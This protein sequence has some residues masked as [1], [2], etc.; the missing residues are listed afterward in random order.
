MMATAERTK[1][2]GE[3]YFRLNARFP[4]TRIRNDR[5]LA[6][7]ESV[8]AELLRKKCDRGEKTYLETLSD[9]M[10]SYEDHAHPIPDITPSQFLKSLLES[11][12]M[13]VSELASRTGLSTSVINAMIEGK[14]PFTVDH[15]E[16]IANEFGLP[17]SAFL[18]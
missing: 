11:N 14:R 6:Q 17:A 7:A 16:T 12:R 9:L 18:S 8:V 13:P 3:S 15:L 10:E 4:I 5:H 2:V 1:S